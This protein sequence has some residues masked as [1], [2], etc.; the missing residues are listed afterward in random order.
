MAKA[1]VGLSRLE[2]EGTLTYEGGEGGIIIYEIKT[3]DEE[4][5]KDAIRHLAK[6]QEF[7]MP[8]SNK[9]DDYR[10]DMAHPTDNITYFE[11]SLS[12][13]CAETGIKVGW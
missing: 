12:T 11:L 6:K 5:R 8:E 13:L 1:S 7:K 10:V 2:S 3:E 9:T 4:L